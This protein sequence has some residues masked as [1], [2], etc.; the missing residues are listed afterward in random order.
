MPKQKYQIKF[1]KPYLKVLDGKITLVSKYLCSKNL[2]SGRPANPRDFI[3]F[4][5]CVEGKIYGEA[6]RKIFTELKTISKI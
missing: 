2:V 3:D 1:R 4:L 6:T 5:H